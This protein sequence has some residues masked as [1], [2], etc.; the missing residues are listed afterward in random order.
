MITPVPHLLTPAVLP[1]HPAAAISGVAQ[2]VAAGE[3]FAQAPSMAALR[4]H[5]S[6]QVQPPK[7][8]LQ[9]LLL[10]GEHG[11]CRAPCAISV[12]ALQPGRKEEVFIFETMSFVAQAGLTM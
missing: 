2:S 1:V 7:V 8:H 4:A 9:V 6:H 10:F 12:T 5:Q 3:L 11:P